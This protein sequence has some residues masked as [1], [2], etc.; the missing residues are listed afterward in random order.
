MPRTSRWLV[1]P[2]L[3]VRVGEGKHSKPHCSVPFTP[4]ICSILTL[5]RGVLEAQQGK[6]CPEWRSMPAR[7]RADE[8]ESWNR[9]GGAG[10]RIWE[11]EARGKGPG[12]PSWGLCTDAPPT[13]LGDR[14]P[15]A[16]PQLLGRSGLLCH[17]TCP[18]Y[19]PRC[20]GHNS[21]VRDTQVNSPWQTLTLRAGSSS[22]GSAPHDPWGAFPRAATLSCL[23]PEVLFHL[24]TG[25]HSQFPVLH[26]Q[27]G[28]ESTQRDALG[29]WV[30]GDPV[31]KTSLK[32]GR[33][34]NFVSK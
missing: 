18:L 31:P 19:S 21:R 30:T 22:K 13:L 17:W 24:T 14:T 34:T 20:Q 12:A 23:Y 15:G 11:M 26:P 4:S 3:G 29:S 6:R 10:Y 25:V 16:V 28:A 33:W 2:L 8:A 32:M 1:S 27:D 5:W 7:R 9:R